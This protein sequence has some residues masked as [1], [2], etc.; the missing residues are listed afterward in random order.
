MTSQTI[1][2]PYTRTELQYLYLITVTVVMWWWLTFKTVYKLGWNWCWIL[3]HYVNFSM[4]LGHT[5]Q[6]LSAFLTATKRLILDYT[7]VLWRQER[8][9]RE[10]LW[11]FANKKACMG[12]SVDVEPNFSASEAYSHISNVNTPKIPGLP[13]WIN[14]VMPCIPQSRWN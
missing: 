7:N 11:N 9:F 10:S 14:E 2:N 6:R 12:S 8:A 3:F 1:W 5:C 4:T 13:K